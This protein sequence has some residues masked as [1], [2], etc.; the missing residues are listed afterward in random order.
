MSRETTG[1]EEMLNFLLLET[2][3]MPFEYHSTQ[4]FTEYFTSQI[5]FNNY[6][7]RIE[8]ETT[9]LLL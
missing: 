4:A 3:N 1:R 2:T 6:R 7:F 5:Q 8:L 9:R